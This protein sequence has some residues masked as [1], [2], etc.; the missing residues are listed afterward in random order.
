V[1]SWLLLLL[2][3]GAVAGAQGGNFAPVRPEARLAFPQDLGSHPGYRTEWW[4]ITGWLD[5]KDGPLGFQVTFFRSRQALKGNNPSRFTPQQILI[6]HCALSDPRRGHLWQDQRVR[7]TGLGLAEAAAGDTHVWI[8]TWALEHRGGVYK[9]DI[10]AADF[11]L[12]LELAQPESPLLNGDAG[13]SRKG[14]LPSDASDYYS[15]PHLQ[16]SGTVLR[17][18]SAATV[19]GEAWLDHEWSS[20]Y[21]DPEAVGWDW[22]GLNLDHGAALMAFRIRTAQGTTLWAGGTYRNGA[23]ETRVYSPADI[24]F[25]PTRRWISPRTGVTYPI[26]WDLRAG[27]NRVHL[28]PLMDDQENDTTMSTGAIYWEGAVRVSDAAARELG[29]GYLELT[30]YG[31]RLRLR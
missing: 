22:V 19:S 31:E 29:K 14:P 7:R 11:A 23:G 13:F 25:T 5:A 27:E 26:E 10:D 2:V 12:H 16:V 3:A 1:K 20:E 6:A 18:A 17:G 21:L 8:D 24:E 9:A 30:G 15:I 4:Y 28:K